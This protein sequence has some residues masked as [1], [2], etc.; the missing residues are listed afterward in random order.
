LPFARGLVFVAGGRP[1]NMHDPWGYDG[2]LVQSKLSVMHLHISKQTM[3]VIE[4]FSA[5]LEQVS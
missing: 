3:S 2:C 1:S 5:S 4:G